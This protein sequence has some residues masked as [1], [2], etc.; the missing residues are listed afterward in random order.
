MADS[1]L[2]RLEILNAPAIE[3]YREHKI[4]LSKEP[5]QIAV[6]AQHNNGGLAGN[7]WWE[8]VNLKHL[9][10][11]GEVNGSH[12]VTRPGGTS[13]TE[14]RAGRRVPGFGVHRREVP[15]KHVSGNGI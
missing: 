12:G 13:C 8:S 3:L 10:P 4:H 2:K 5:L 14:R 9:F 1:P 6:C 7:V 11:V 15:R